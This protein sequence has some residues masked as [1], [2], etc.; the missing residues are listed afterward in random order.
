MHPRRLCPHGMLAI[1][2]C[3][4]FLGGCASTK[5]SD[6]HTSAS[7]ASGP[8]MIYVANFELG[9]ATIK[10]DPG[11][12]T[13][14][15]R[16]IHF[17]D[18]DPVQTLQRL[19]TLLEDTLVADL[20]QKHLSA[21]RL[22]PGE[23]PTSGWIVSGQFLEV[24]EGNHLQSAVLGFGAGT[25]DTRL[26]VSVED[27]ALAPG[28]NLL[29]FNLDAKGNKAPGGAAAAAVT[30]SPLGMAAKFVLDRNSTDKDIKRAAGEIAGQLEKLAADHRN[31]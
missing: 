5:V 6:I 9:A 16:L 25:S 23:H 17:G 30:H 31:D 12:L 8:V 22:S 19:S 29:D 13:G 3:T 15:P 7:A 18:K 4:A 26:A 27:A 2:L 21:R 14:R 10:A 11:T 28:H 24:N 20:Q 1:L